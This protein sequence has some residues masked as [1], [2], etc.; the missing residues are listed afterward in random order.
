MPEGLRY[1][2]TAP[3]WFGNLPHDFGV[4]ANNDGDYDD[5]GDISGLNLPFCVPVPTAVTGLSIVAIVNTDVGTG[6][7]FYGNALSWDN[8]RCDGLGYPDDPIQFL[9]RIKHNGQVIEDAAIVTEHDGKCVYSH[10][11]Y[12]HDPLYDDPQYDGPLSEDKFGPGVRHLYEVTTLKIRLTRM[13]PGFEIVEESPPATI[14]ECADDPRAIIGC[15]LGD[16]VLNATNVFARRYARG[17]VQ[18]TWDS[19]TNHGALFDN[20]ELP[21]GESQYAVFVSGGKK[22]TTWPLA[23]LP[24]LFGDP[25][26]RGNSYTV[27]H[28]TSTAMNDNDVSF[29]YTLRLLGPPWAS[30]ETFLKIE[31]PAV[32][33]A[34]VVSCYKVPH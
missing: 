19:V 22:W 2:L 27:V 18:I 17:E 3:N 8:E 28:P 10:T 13:F 12:Y 9:W 29:T 31:C 1:L 30:P 20:D 34:S 33:S 21:G 16:D 23:S 4:D 7:T 14:F 26:G 25:T 5:P 6:Q 32:G 15:W 11:D 24:G